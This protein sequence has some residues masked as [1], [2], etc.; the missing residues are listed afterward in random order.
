MNQRHYWTKKHESNWLSSWVHLE[1]QLLV[2][3]SFF[4]RTDN[5]FYTEVDDVTCLLSV[6]SVAYVQHITH[7]I[8]CDIMSLVVFMLTFGLSFVI[9]LWPARAGLAFIPQRERE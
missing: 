3:L 7:Y 9:C 1:R 8:S 4:S 5:S 6:L 2:I